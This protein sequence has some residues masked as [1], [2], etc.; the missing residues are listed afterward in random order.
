M[1]RQRPKR[2][3][4]ARRLL[5]APRSPKRGESI[6]TT[7]RHIP[8]HQY[9]P[10]PQTAG[11]DSHPDTHAVT[12]NQEPADSWPPVDL[13]DMHGFDGMAVAP[14]PGDNGQADP[15]TIY[16]GASSDEVPYNDYND[17]PSMDYPGSL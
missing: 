14:L 9:A 1:A 6:T 4:N 12:T 2:S 11:L 15:E 13:P 7:T 5:P 17:S 10:T 8:P 16:G 3:K